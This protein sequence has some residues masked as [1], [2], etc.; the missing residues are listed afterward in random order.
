MSPL[1]IPPPRS[2]SGFALDSLALRALGSGSPSI[3]P[4]NMF[5]NPTPNR[6]VLD[7]TLFSPNPNFLATPLL[8]NIS[9]QNY[10]VGLILKYT[11]DN[12]LDGRPGGFSENPA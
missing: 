6:G 12:I 2:I 10:V 1:P 5:N 11:S 7:Q 3:H 8:P 4:S 9:F